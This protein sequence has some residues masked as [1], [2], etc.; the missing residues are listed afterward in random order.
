MVISI[1]MHMIAII[2]FTIVILAVIIF[3]YILYIVKPS[4]HIE[5]E[6]VDSSVPDSGN[7][8][9]KLYQRLSNIAK[10]ASSTI[11]IPIDEDGIEVVG[12]MFNKKS[13]VVL[14]DPNN[15][16]L[17]I[18]D[19]VIVTDESNQKIIVPVVVSNQKVSCTLVKYPLKKISSIVYRN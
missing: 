3:C 8:M 6:V 1:D 16:V 9:N 19:L 14:C 5:Q 11:Q 18:G 10:D 4:H 2:V 17:N 15:Q 7:G 13:D 12:V